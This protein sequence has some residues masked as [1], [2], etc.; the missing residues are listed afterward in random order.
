MKKNHDFHHN[1][2]DNQWQKGQEDK[3]KEGLGNNSGNSKCNR[4]DRRNEDLK[5][6]KKW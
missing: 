3:R 5:I 1:R 2:E 4:A 6:R